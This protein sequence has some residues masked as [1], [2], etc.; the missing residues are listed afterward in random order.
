[1]EIAQSITL[2]ELYLG[3]PLQSSITYKFLVPEPEALSSIG[4]SEDGSGGYSVWPVASIHTRIER[5]RQ[6]LTKCGQ[7]RSAST[8]RSASNSSINAEAIRLKY[9]DGSHDAETLLV[10]PAIGNL[11]VITKVPFQNP[12]IYDATGPLALR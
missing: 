7:G 2:I 11:Y 6:D 8:M 10:H 4:P 3:D 5:W 9:P 12:V 1:M